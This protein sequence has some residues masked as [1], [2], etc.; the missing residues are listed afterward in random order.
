MTEAH[1]FKE[2][3]RRIEDAY[4]KA[5]ECGTG[6][7]DAF[8]ATTNLMR[9]QLRRKMGLH[10]EEDGEGFFNMPEQD[11]RKCVQWNP[12]APQQ[13]QVQQQQHAS[14]IAAIQ[15][16][17][18]AT[19]GQLMLGNGDQ[20]YIV[21]PPPLLGATGGGVLAGGF[22]ATWACHPISSSRFLLWKRAQKP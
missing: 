16:Q 6:M 10:R 20:Q 17:I 2:E 9:S 1:G 13:Q 4:T 22:A 5:V 19:P 12:K 3:V 21:P 15:K 11:Y 14:Q 7:A 18:A 8:L